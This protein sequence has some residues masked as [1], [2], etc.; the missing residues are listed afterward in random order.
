M[1]SDRNQASGASPSPEDERRLRHAL[2]GAAGLGVDSDLATTV[3]RQ[4][5]RETRRRRYAV[6]AGLV[7][8]SAAL[9]VTLSQG[10]V[11]GRADLTPATSSP[12]TQHDGGTATRTGAL[13]DTATNTGTNT[14]TGTSTG[15]DTSSPT[16][17]TT[18]GGRQP[19]LSHV[20][21]VVPAGMT[22][23]HANIGSIWITEPDSWEGARLLCEPADAGGC[24]PISLVHNPPTRSEAGWDPEL[25]FLGPD[26]E[27]RCKVTPSG[28][29]APVTRTSRLEQGSAVVDGE[30]ATWSTWSLTC[31]D[32]TTEVAESWW[33]PGPQVAVYGI[34]SPGVGAVA[35]SLRFP[36]AEVLDIHAARITAHDAD[37]VRV[38]LYGPPPTG[39]RYSYDIWVLTGR[40]ELTLT[41]DTRCLMSTDDGDPQRAP[42]ADYLASADA[43]RMQ[44][45]FADPDGTLI[46]LMA[47]EA[48]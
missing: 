22:V 12:T 14:D 26:G 35:R 9:A 29:G 24:P 25:F 42:C 17:D 45:A 33:F 36:E 44:I 19:I 13:D 46:Q 4:A 27:M 3:W 8:A 20:S 10:W 37:T 1:M 30:D 11:G 23:D 47:A 18:V 2:D 32:G 39:E 40:S 48:P 16:G 15:T 38:D 7:A 21:A 43:D 28:L 5:E 31:D 6:G 34:D 41:D